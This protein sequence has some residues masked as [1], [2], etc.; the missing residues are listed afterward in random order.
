MEKEFYL[1]IGGALAVICIMFGSCMYSESLEEECR[2]KAIEK[3][4]TAIEIQGIC[5]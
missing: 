2:L 3:G 5:K 4:Y 1:F